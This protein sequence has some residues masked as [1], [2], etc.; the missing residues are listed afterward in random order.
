MPTA[1]AC[2]ALF[3]ASTLLLACVPML[4]MR[5]AV[6]VILL[7]VLTALLHRLVVRTERP[8]PDVRTFLLLASPFLLMLL[9]LLRSSNALTAWHI[10][11]R[12][13]ILALAPFVV[14]MLR[15]PVDAGLRDRATDVFALSS[16]AL[17]LFAN[18]SILAQGLAADLSFAQSYRQQ[19]AAITGIHPPFGAFLFLLGALFMIE[20]ALRSPERRSVRITLALAL[21][22]AGALIASR[23]P[24]VAFALASLLMLWWHPQRKRA[25]RLAAALI[26][27]LALLVAL[28]PSAR[29]RVLEPFRTTLAI[30]AAGASNSVSER[31]VIGHCTVELLEDNWLWG[32]GQAAVQPALDRCYSQF[33]DPRYLNGSYSTHCQP[34]HWWLSFGILG[35]MLFTVLFAVP[36][37]RAWHLRDARLAGFLLF[38][39][40]CCLTENVLARQ[41]GVVPYAFFLALLS[42][43]LFA[44]GTSAPA[45]SKK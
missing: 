1:K 31:F 2:T 44:S 27:G 10:A 34:L 35:A 11:E 22:V 39:L 18:I 12:S 20:R 33:N 3:R 36:L 26:G 25:L 16:L 37:R 29:Q 32:L 21:A 17:A 4:G 14:L 9:D 23:T 43:S 15:P 5:P 45:R 19:F 41:W 13:S 42:P 28:I 30:P 8:P 7:W 38:V 40:I 6:G 24:L